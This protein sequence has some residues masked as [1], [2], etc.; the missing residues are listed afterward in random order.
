MCNE[1]YQPANGRGCIDIN[2]CLGQPCGKGATCQNTQGGYE[3]KC[4]SGL[5]GDPNVACLGEISTARQCSRSGDKS[6]PA[7][8]ICSGDGQCVCQRGFQRDAVGGGCQDVDECKSATSARPVC[9]LNAVCKNLPG[10]YDCQCPPGFNGNPFVQ[11][12]RCADGGGTDC[13]CEAPYRQEADGTCLLASC[14][15]K[16]DCSEGAD[17]VS[18]AGKRMIS[19]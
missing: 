19:I 2:E 8:E 10:S 14:K 4:P 15:S 16:A 3:C 1:G 13:G 12:S 7:G 18:I 9:G 11:C 17:C 6:C 5:G